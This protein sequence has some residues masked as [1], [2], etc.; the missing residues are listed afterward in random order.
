VAM[1]IIAAKLASVSSSF[2]ANRLSQSGY[3]A[4]SRAE[5]TAGSSTQG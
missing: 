3:Q 4:A 1:P 5:T 2:M